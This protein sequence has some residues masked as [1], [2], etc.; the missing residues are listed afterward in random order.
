VADGATLQDALAGGEEVELVCVG[1][2]DAVRKAGLKPI[3]VMS[4]DKVVKVVG[5]GDLNLRGYDH[6]A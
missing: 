6:F 4:G 2:D 5:A 1:P 3:G